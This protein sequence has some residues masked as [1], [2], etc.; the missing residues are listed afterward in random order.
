MLEDISSLS[1]IIL[2]HIYKYSFIF[3]L[4]YS[5]STPEVIAKLKPV[6]IIVGFIFDNKLS[7]LN[8]FFWIWLKKR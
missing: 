3:C 4:L 8:K 6:I 5:F 2:K 7:K 1:I